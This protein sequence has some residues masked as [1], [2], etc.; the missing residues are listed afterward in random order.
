MV[1]NI[2]GAFL[3]NGPGIAMRSHP[4]YADGRPDKM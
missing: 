2:R 4:T 1:A 3:K